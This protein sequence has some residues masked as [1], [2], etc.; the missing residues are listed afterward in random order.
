[1]EEEIIGAIATGGDGTD[2][3]ITI[4]GIIGITL[5]HPI[6]I[7]TTTGVHLPITG[8]VIMDT[9]PTPIITT[10]TTTAALIR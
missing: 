4:I 1:M 5:L 2:G 3:I 8:E 9:T 6:T 7:L 10:I